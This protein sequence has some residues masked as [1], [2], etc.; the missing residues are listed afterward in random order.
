METEA[1]REKVPVTPLQAP[2]FDQP[3][4]EDLAAAAQAG[5]EPV[6]DGVMGYR[7]QAVVDAARESSDSGQR[8]AVESW[9][10]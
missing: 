5:R 10:D 1:G 4:L 6:C 7:V 9:A 3:M 2:Y 8:V